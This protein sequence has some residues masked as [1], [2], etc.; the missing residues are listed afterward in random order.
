[1]KICEFE[2]DSGATDWVFVPDIDEAEEFYLDYSG[3]GDDAGMMRG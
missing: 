2:F 3:C 1:M